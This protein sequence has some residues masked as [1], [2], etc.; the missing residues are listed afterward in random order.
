MLRLSIRGWWA[1]TNVHPHFC[2][3]LWTLCSTQQTTWGNEGFDR[4][5][6][7]LWENKCN[8]PFTY[9]ALRGCAS[10]GWQENWVFIRS[11][12]SCYC[13]WGITFF[14]VAC[15]LHRP[16]ANEYFQSYGSNCLWPTQLLHTHQQLMGSRIALS[17]MY[18]NALSRF[19]EGT[20]KC[21]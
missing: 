8:L 14:L 3:C 7:S 19:G 20:K 2:L 18:E 15:R 6:F 10:P 5:N 4:H 12:E 17:D 16:A 13:S 1:F 11:L 21:N 9:F